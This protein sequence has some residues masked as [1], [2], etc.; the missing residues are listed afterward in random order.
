MSE[1][2][3]SDNPSVVETLGQ[4]AV[5]IST[6]DIMKAV[7]QQIPYQLRRLADAQEDTSKALWHLVKEIK[8]WAEKQKR[9]NIME[10]DPDYWE[11][12]IKQVQAQRK[13]PIKKKKSRGKKQK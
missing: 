13:K 6:E 5:D 10:Q 2:E 11:A 8:P 1:G 9:S 3:K 12:V 4:V 7:V